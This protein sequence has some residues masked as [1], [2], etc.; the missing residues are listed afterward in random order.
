MDKK[1]FAA[2][3]RFICGALLLFPGF[4]LAHAQSTWPTKPVRI[5]V[6]YPP[7]GLADVMARSVAQQLTDILGQPV[8]VE[9]K[10]GANGNVAGDTV[11][12]L[13]A[14]G[15]TFC[16]CSTVIESV[17][18]FLYERMPFDP[19]NDVMPVASTGRVQLF[20]VAKNSLP[21]SSFEEFLALARV[22]NPPLAYGSAGSGSSP[23]LV[24]EMF[25]NVGK[26][27]ATHVP[28][29]GAAP[30][31]QDL[32]A[33]QVD[34][35][36]DPGLSIPHVKAGKLKIF[37][38][39]S[40]SRSGLVPN[41]PTLAEL[42]FKGLDFDTWFGLYARAGTSAAIVTRLNEA[43]NKALADPGLK[44]R[45]RDLGA[46]PVPMTPTEFKA[47]A[48]RERIAFGKLIRDQGI[49]AD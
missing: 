48:N 29:R 5:L 22:G 17:N 1:F 46:D 36:F 20:L 15:Y 49:K 33:G 30:A 9:N 12:K 14:D 31:I 44:S 18:P 13:P 3:T 41:V 23:H 21:A 45:Y 25:K 43:V 34:F 6:A 35:M 42:G 27:Q 26:I 8:I 24:G 2:A 32:L 47:I 38:V 40:N 19:Q 7:G 28:Y 4:Q 39:V 37:A 16:L 10:P 11:A